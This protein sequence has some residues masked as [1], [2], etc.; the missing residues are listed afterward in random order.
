M[1]LDNSL[2]RTEHIYGPPF[3]SMNPGKPKSVINSKT[4]CRLGK[5]RSVKFS[6]SSLDCHEIFSAC[7][8]H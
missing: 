3:L 5:T 6:V 1:D 7:V 2:N 8:S 4:R